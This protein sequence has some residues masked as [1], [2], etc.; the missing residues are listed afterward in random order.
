MHYR[1]QFARKFSYI[2]NLN[3]SVSSYHDRVNEQESTHFLAG[4][5]KLIFELILAHYDQG[6]YD[7]L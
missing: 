1:E 7:H 6:K 2:F 5:H 3:G 4:V